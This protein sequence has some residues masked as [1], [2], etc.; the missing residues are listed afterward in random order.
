MVLRARKGF[1][2]AAVE[3]GL[4]GGIV[5]VFHFGNS[6]VHVCVCVC[7]RENAPGEACGP[8][9]CSS[10]SSAPPRPR[11]LYAAPSP[12]LKHTPDPHGK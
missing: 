12:P 3:E 10:Q 2:R 6:Q 11:D 7:V 1:V 5:P 9:C 4:D 8:C